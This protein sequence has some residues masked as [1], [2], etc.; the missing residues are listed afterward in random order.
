MYLFIQKYL[1]S[2]HSMADACSKWI[3]LVNSGK[4][5]PQ[6]VEVRGWFVG[7]VNFCDIK[8][9]FKGYKHTNSPD[10]KSR[11]SG[12]KKMWIPYTVIEELNLNWISTDSISHEFDSFAS[13]NLLSYAFLSICMKKIH[14]YL[15]MMPH[16]H[17]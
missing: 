5:L 6:G 9:T 2:T 8:S 17:S 3:V 14:L 11:I 12:R 4:C 7:F 10:E 1:L 15:L 13:I 16:S